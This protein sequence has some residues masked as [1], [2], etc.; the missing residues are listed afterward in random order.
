ML[1]VISRDGIYHISAPDN[2][3]TTRTTQDKDKYDR[4]QD[5]YL[6]VIPGKKANV[7]NLARAIFYDC[8]VNDFIN[9][10][11]LCLLTAELKCHIKT[12]KGIYEFRVQNYDQF[13]ALLD[14]IAKYIE[15]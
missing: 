5:V 12:E 3:R 11:G 6:E 8:F 10:S 2:A 1:E 14:D 4:I 15:V 7:L 9:N 13:G